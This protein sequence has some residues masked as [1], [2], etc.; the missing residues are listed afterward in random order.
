MSTVHEVVRETIKVIWCVTFL[1]LE[2]L[3]ALKYDQD[4]KLY[5]ISL[6]G[7]FLTNTIHNYLFFAFLLDYTTFKSGN[8]PKY[9]PLS[10][11]LI[12]C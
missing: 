5:P 11:I 10:L 4:Q 1:D 3:E 7:F 8:F 6:S 2:L 9:F 12:H